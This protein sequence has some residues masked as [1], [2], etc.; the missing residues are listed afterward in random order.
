YL[1][2]ALSLAAIGTVAVMVPL[3]DE[4][5][6]LVR[7]GL[8]SLQSNPPPGL[9]EL[10]R[11]TGLHQKPALSSEDIAFSIG[12]RLNAAGRLGQAQLGVELLTV[13]EGERAAA[14]AE[15]LHQ[16]NSSR[17]SLERSVFL[18][19]QKQAKTEFDP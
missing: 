15:Y 2:R 8:R 14:L 4:N 12:P 7:H 17:E 13:P 1:M 11:L 9:A 6:V 19:A 16:L 10:M 5:R 3:V 18:A